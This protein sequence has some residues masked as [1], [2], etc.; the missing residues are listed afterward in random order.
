MQILY[1]HGTS[2]QIRSSWK[3]YA[4][5]SLGETRNAGL[6]ICL[7]IILCTLRALS[8][9][10]P[11]CW[12]CCSSKFPKITRE[13]LDVL[14]KYLMSHFTL[15]KCNGRNPPVLVCWTGS[16]GSLPMTPIVHNSYYFWRLASGNLKPA[17]AK[18][19]CLQEKRGL[20]AFSVDY[21][22]ISRPFKNWREI[23]HITSNPV[24]QVLA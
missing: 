14:G 20:W 22:R 16:T 13:A 12:T 2:L 8:F 10:F 5:I 11:V 19:S 21:E 24:S 1:L 3:W 9:L 17:R 23:I 4:S 18:T 15:Y 7:E 6:E